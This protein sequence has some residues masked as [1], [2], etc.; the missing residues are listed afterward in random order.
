MTDVCL[1]LGAPVYP[2]SCGFATNVLSHLRIHYLEAEYS[3]QHTTTVLGL[4]FFYSDI[5][6]KCKKTKNNQRY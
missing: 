5:R 6:D 1:S 2:K 3:P 4:A